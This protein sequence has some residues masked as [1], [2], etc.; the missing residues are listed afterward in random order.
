MC[1][2]SIHL[3]RDGIW[4]GWYPLGD[5]VEGTAAARLV[6]S[7]ILS[8]IPRRVWRVGPSGC[9]GAESN[10]RGCSAR[11]GPKGNTGTTATTHTQKKGPSPSRA[12]GSRRFPRSRCISYS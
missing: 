1:H 9:Q 11:K 3:P 5:L 6:V 12:K 4:L 7:F 8:P 10:K 2:T